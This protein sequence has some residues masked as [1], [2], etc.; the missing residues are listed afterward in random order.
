MELIELEST[1][2]FIDTTVITVIAVTTSE[3]VYFNVLFPSEYRYYFELVSNTEVPVLIDHSFQLYYQ[4]TI[5]VESNGSGGIYLILEADPDFTPFGLLTVRI[6][7]SQELYD[8]IIIAMSNPINS[9]EGLVPS[10]NGNACGEVE[11]VLLSTDTGDQIKIDLMNSPPFVP[12]VPVT[13][14][15]LQWNEVLYNVM[16]LPDFEFVYTVSG[17]LGITFIDPR[18]CF[19]REWISFPPDWTRA[20]KDFSGVQ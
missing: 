9:P 12:E 13:I 17:D 15:T 16:N 14:K 2:L 5:M 7:I 3:T 4:R 18:Y 11:F 1:E 20:I 8:A 10:P 6:N 19:L